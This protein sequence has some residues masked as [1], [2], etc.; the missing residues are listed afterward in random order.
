MATRRDAVEQ[1][2]GRKQRSRQEHRSQIYFDRVGALKRAFKGGGYGDEVLRYFPIGI[3][4][5]IESYFRGVYAELIDTSEQYATRITPL[6]RD[7]RIDWRAIRAIEGKRIST[8]ETIGAS[9][10]LSNL[11]DIQRVMDALLATDFLKQLRDLKHDRGKQKDQPI[12]SDPDDTFKYVTRA[13]ELRHIFCHES[14]SGVQASRDEIE[15]CLDYCALFMN[16]T[17]ALLWTK[18]PDYGLTQQEMTSRAG[19]THEEAR[20]TMEEMLA[21]LNSIVEKDARKALADSQTK[22]QNLADANAFFMAYLYTGGS[23]YEMVRLNSFTSETKNR[24][25]QLTTFLAEWK[26]LTE[27]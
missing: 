11:G 18:H 21:K 22:W 20:S 2:L 26:S 17:E 8:G 19:K 6:I 12:L 10:S 3:I 1:V 9:L 27:L 25:N 14:A 23:M 7:L 24:I 4:A 5:T 15:S 13:F 16:T